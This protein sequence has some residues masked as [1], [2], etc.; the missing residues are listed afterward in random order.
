LFC[1]V[2]FFV[3]LGRV[4]ILLGKKSGV[5]ELTVKMIIYRQVVYAYSRIDNFISNERY[6][7]NRNYEF[8]GIFCKRRLILNYI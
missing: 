3:F 4:V 7:G 5:F 2:L 6:R 8:E 1:F